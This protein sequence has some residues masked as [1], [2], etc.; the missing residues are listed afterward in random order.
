M[1]NSPWQSEK[2]SLRNSLA[3]SENSFLVSGC[4]GAGVGLRPLKPDLRLEG[5]REFPACLVQHQAEVCQPEPG[6][7]IGGGDWSLCRRG[8]ECVGVGGALSLYSCCHQNCLRKL[9]SAR[10][11]CQA[12]HLGPPVSLPGGNQAS[13][14]AS[15][16]TVTVLPAEEGGVGV[17]T[18]SPGQ[19]AG[20][21]TIL[22]VMKV[23]MSPDSW[24][25]GPG[26]VWLLAGSSQ[27]VEICRVGVGKVRTVYF[28][29]QPSA[30]NMILGGRGGGCCLPPHTQC[31][32]PGPS[33]I[34]CKL[35]KLN[36]NILCFD[37]KEVFSSVFVS[38]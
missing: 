12:A 37:Y 32:E 30:N 38:L 23:V 21:G 8:E 24:T 31:W 11:A 4:P 15:A 1:V 10:Q 28:C 33:Q 5:F 19:E 2:L 20:G 25:A 29:L 26:Q 3:W 36:N 14:R 34:S 22:L 6:G 35:V 27:L 17:R 9:S 16:T 7:E 18:P 13:N